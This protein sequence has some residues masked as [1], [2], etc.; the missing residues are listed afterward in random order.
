[1]TTAVEKFL[2]NQSISH[3]WIPIWNRLRVFCE[4]DVFKFASLVG[5]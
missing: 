3:E 1:M 4:R 5:I 2:N